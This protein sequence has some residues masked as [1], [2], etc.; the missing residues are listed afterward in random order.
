M[1]LK[2]STGSNYRGYVEITDRLPR[3]RGGRLTHPAEN[4]WFDMLVVA[5][6]D[7]M[8]AHRGR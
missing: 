4:A 1:S 5:N 3:K 6:S 8:A 2:A 7:A